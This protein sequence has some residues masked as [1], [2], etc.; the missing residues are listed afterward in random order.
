MLEEY[1]EH[2]DHG[3]SSLMELRPF[4][5]DGINHNTT[6]M[7]ISL[8]TEISIE[9]KGLEVQEKASLRTDG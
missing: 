5:G 6:S 7:N 1:G 9:N 3:L 4:Q 2:L 8:K